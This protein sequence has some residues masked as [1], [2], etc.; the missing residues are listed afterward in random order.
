M[1]RKIWKAISILFMFLCIS[2]TDIFATVSNKQF[3]DIKSPAAVVID[4]DTGRVLYDKNADEK[5]SIASLTKMM[6]SILLVENCNMDEL[7]QVPSEATWIG[8]SEV[9]LKAKD[10]LT[11]KSL[12]YGMLLPSRK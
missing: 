8:G 4:N 11:A 6:T 9:G 5:R 2:N 1:K 10:M 7:I 12:L 3:V